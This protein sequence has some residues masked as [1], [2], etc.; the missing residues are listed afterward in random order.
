MSVT[1]PGT[2][3]P[4]LLVFAGEGGVG[5]TTLAAATALK[6]SLSGL[7]VAVMTIDPAPRL[8]DA[9]GLD[10]LG[11]E[12]LLVGNGEPDSGKTGSL[13]ALRLD[14][15]GTFDRMVDRLADDNTVAERIKANPVYQAVAASTGSSGPY[16]AFQ[17]LHELA[18]SKLWDLI[19]V[20]TP[21]AL[22]A[23]EL[24]S[25]PSRMAALLETRAVALLVD[26]ARAAAGRG[27]R[28]A[29]ATA[30]LLLGM[31]ERVTGA[32]LLGQ[33]SSFVTDFARMMENM[34]ER[35][36]DIETLLATPPSC[37]ALVGRASVASANATLALREEL[38]DRGFAVAP[39]VA[40][41][42]TPPATAA[43]RSKIDL[44]T[45]APPG[46]AQL[47]ERINAELGLLR[48]AEAEVTAR[49]ED[50]THAAV[51]RVEDLVVEAGSLEDLALLGAEL[52]DLDDL[53]AAA[54]RAE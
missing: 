46:C 17:R 15:S 29:R 54:V 23:E 5:K 48:Q 53:L 30:T 9:L 50:A 16:M 47:L 33:V 22:H 3:R 52:P 13:H 14:T 38:L 1:D 25:A 39:I 10:R 21:P 40:N 24:L 2:A 19:V 18:E 11:D 36:R 12:P 4:R 45:D 28:L 49:I 6:A 35:S 37:F 41:R 44:S 34:V 31:V 7:R 43:G 20:D 26:P 27:S 51:L 32:A 8:A 42:L